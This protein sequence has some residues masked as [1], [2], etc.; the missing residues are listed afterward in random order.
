MAILP[1]N[2]EGEQMDERIKKA[3]DFSADLTKQL[4]SLATGIIALTVTFKKD[5][6]AHSAN[7]SNALAYCT[8]YSLL[9]SV[10]FGILT[11]S[12]LTG[13]LDAKDKTATLTIF[14]WNITLFSVLQFLAFGF[15]LSCA[16]IFAA[17][18]LQS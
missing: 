14:A 5:F 9:A 12:A 16:V 17:K 2:S 18:G 10:A 1:V 3:F 7:T 8:W 13:N 15:G 4:I 6:F 11:L